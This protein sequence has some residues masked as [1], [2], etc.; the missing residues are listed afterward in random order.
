MNIDTSVLSNPLLLAL[1]PGVLILSLC[2]ITGLRARLWR[3]GRKQPGL[4]FC[5]LLLVPKRYLVDLHNIVARDT[6]SAHM[7]AASAAGFCLALFSLL[8]YSVVSGI[9]GEKLAGWVTLVSSI[10]MLGGIIA[11]YGRRYAHPVGTSGQLSKGIWLQQIFLLFIVAVCM[12]V[13]GLLAVF[14]SWITSEFILLRVLVTGILITTVC[15]LGVTA[16]YGGLLKHV[17]AGVFHLAFHPRPERF[18]EGGISSA[19]QPLDFEQGRLGIE[20]A[21]DFK[22]NMLLGFDACVQCGRCEVACPAFAAGMP[23]NPKKMIQDFVVG[24]Q[25]GKICFPYAGRPHP[26]V[27]PKTQQHMKSGTILPGLVPGE[28]IWS[29]TTCRACVQ[30][31]P[32]MIEHVDAVIDMRRFQT[33][34]LG[35]LPSIAPATLQIIRETDNAAGRCLSERL[36][37]TAGLELNKFSTVKTMDVLLWLGNGAFVQR[38]QRTLRALV[39]LLNRANVRFAVLA[40]EE[41]DSGDLARRLGDEVTFQ[42][43]AR[44]NIEILSKYR[45]D[46][47]VTADPHDFHSLKNE[48]PAFGGHYT[49]KHHTTFLCQLIDR[50]KL[51][52][53]AF[54]QSP[55]SV[56]YHDPC[57]LGRYNGEVV[58]PRRLLRFAGMELIEMKRAG[59]NSRCCGGGGGSQYTDIPGERRI[60]DIRMED[61]RDTGASTLVVACPNCAVMLEGTT[62]KR[63]AVKDIAEI[64]A[65]RLES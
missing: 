36:D 55:A 15:V 65:E 8:V 13:I 28:T 46:T 22:W 40:D 58:M 59:L 38:N 37:W 3:R 57:Y 1:A 10:I 63:L 24:M 25:G 32:M 12:F 11:V 23:L 50:G 6:L 45:F 64:L 16:M 19:L 52:K 54:N 20:K 7:H 42:N 30:E 62:G 31:C 33:L 35:N 34:E 4:R 48:Y 39:T 51:A 53:S 29:C 2:I 21:E 43:L 44:R 47:I 61:A 26:G 5:N 27:D 60:A 17:V 14:D 9:D 41:L 18:R 49:V 56:T